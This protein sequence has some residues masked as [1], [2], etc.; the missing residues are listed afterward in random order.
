MDNKILNIEEDI[1]DVK[2]YIKILGFCLAFVAALTIIFAIF[3]ADNLRELNG[4]TC[5]PYRAVDYRGDLDAWVDINGKVV[6]IAVEE[7]TYDWCKE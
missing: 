2:E 5:V 6:L 1:K 3:V 4:E 7:D